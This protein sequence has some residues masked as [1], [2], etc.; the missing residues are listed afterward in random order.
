M[1][2]VNRTL[3]TRDHI[4]IGVTSCMLFIC[5]K[6]MVISPF[7]SGLLLWFNMNLF[8]AYCRWRRSENM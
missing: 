3:E 2:L 5:Y 1:I 7:S 8:N 6:M 4:M